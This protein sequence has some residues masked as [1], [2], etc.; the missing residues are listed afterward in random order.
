MTH[1]YF[2][3]IEIERRQ[4]ELQDRLARRQ[5]YGAPCRRQWRLVDLLLSLWGLL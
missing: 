5:R 2:L 3:E 4:R 1:P